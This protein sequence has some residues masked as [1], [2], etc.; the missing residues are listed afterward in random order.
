MVI[1]IADTSVSITPGTGAQVDARSQPG[2]DL[3][4]VVTIGD[5]DTSPIAAVDAVGFTVRPGKTATA[6]TTRVA[7]AITSTQLLAANANRLN[8][9]I[10]NDSTDTLYVKY[11]TAASATSKKF[12]LKAGEY[13]EMPTGGTIHTGIIH[14]LWSGTNGAADVNEETA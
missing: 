11:G 8:A 9:S 14:G 1:Y 6:T 4:Q 12:A 7:A 3:R 13:W 10:F 5:G 2:G